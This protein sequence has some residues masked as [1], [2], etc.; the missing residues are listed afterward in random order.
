[1][2]GVL[3]FAVKAIPVSES[4][5]YPTPMY[6]GKPAPAKKKSE[7]PAPA[8]EEETAQADSPE[9]NPQMAGLIRGV[10]YIT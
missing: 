3:N 9:G 10:A 6:G 7:S 4:Y 2:R 1:M 5:T 8:E